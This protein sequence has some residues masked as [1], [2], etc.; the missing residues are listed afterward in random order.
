MNDLESPPFPT[1]SDS[2][3]STRQEHLV[4]VIAGRRRNRRRG[5]LALS[6]GVLIASGVTTALLVLA[7]PGTANAFGAWS[8]VP[9]TPASGQVS[10]AV[11]T[12]EA[13]VAT[14]PTDKTSGLA[15]G[16][17][18]VSLVD[19]RGPFTLVLFGANIATSLMCVNGPT[20]SSS[21]QDNSQVTAIGGQPALP[22]AGQLS[23]DRLQAESASDG[24]VYT[25]AQGSVG[26][27][28]MTATLV[29]S[30]GLDVVTTSGKGFF[31]AWWPGSAVATSAIL[32]TA[33]GTTT[34]PISY[35]LHSIGDSGNTVKRSIGIRQ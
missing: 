7:I 29:L 23:V 9:T 35:G 33:M 18:Q 4:R 19:T 12:C 2:R 14:P 24:Q 34:Q 17:T 31:L 27:G 22:E 28:V 20:I 6:G 25:I 15:T 32:T 16:A 5:A 8:P 10:S 3:L 26:A 30:D 13:A 21:A 1:L 11:A